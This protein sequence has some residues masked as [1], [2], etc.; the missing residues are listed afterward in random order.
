ME[1]ILSRYPGASHNLIKADALT[2]WLPR[3]ITSLRPNRSRARMAPDHDRSGPGRLFAGASTQQ[4]VHKREK[5]AKLYLPVFLHV[6]WA[7]VIVLGFYIDWWLVPIAVPR[8]AAHVAV[9]HR[10]LLGLSRR[11]D[12]H[13]LRGLW[14]RGDGFG[15]G[16]CGGRRWCRLPR[17]FFIVARRAS[18]GVQR[19][20]ST[21]RVQISEDVLVVVVSH[22]DVLVGY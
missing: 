13:R 8:R 5:K 12:G 3:N 20:V 2:R 14:F 9:V 22:G 4:P 7:I 17:G 11:R 19:R 21:L 15:L 16:P 18:A 1:S 6:N 10:I